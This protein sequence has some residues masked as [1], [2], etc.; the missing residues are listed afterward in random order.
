MYLVIE[1][2]EGNT[3]T[4][5]AVIKPDP[6]EGRFLKPKNGACPICS[7]GLNIKHTVRV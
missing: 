7:S 2:K 6:Y 3:L 5:E 1:K 4:I